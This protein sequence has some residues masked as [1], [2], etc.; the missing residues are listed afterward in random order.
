M[1][2]L[3]INHFKRA[4]ATDIENSLVS[5]IIVDGTATARFLKRMETVRLGKECNR[6]IN[7]TGKASGPITEYKHQGQSH[8]LDQQS[9]AVFKQGLKDN[10]NV[11]TL[12]TYEAITEGK[13]TYK[14]Q[15]KTAEK[16]KFEANKQKPYSTK[17]ND[18]KQTPITKDVKKRQL[19]EV[20]GNYV[21]EILPLGY[22]LKRR[23]PRLLHIMPISMIYKE[24][25]YQLKTKD[26]SLN[27]IQAF[28]TEQCFE[29]ETK[30]LISFEKFIEETRMLVGGIN[31]DIF[32][33]I[34]FM[35]KNVQNLEGKSYLSMAQLNLS[36]EAKHYFQQF[37][38]NNQSRYKFDATDT[39]LASKATLCEHFYT[40][41]SLHL[42]VFITW[43][44]A[45]GF[46]IDAIIRTEKNHVFF[47]FVSKKQSK[48][49]LLP[50]LLPQRVKRLAN[51]AR[52]SK[53][54]LLFL[55]WKENQLHS[56][57][58]FE[59]SRMDE[60]A[61]VAH[62]THL[63]SGK[64]FKISNTLSKKPH[65]EKMLKMLDSINK[66]DPSAAEKIQTRIKETI[67]QFIITD[68]SRI[69]FQSNMFTEQLKFE[70]GTASETLVFAGNKQVRL[71]DEKIIKE[72][73]LG[74]IH[75]PEITKLKIIP[76][77]SSERYKYKMEIIVS[78]ADTTL[79][80]Q[81]IDFSRTGLG[82]L[83]KGHDTHFDRNDLVNINFPTLMARNVNVSLENVPFIVKLVKHTK[84]GVFLGILRCNEECSND[85][86]NFFND[87][88]ERNKKKLN[89]CLKDK[90]ERIDMAF[91]EAY[92]TENIQTI[93]IIINDDQTEGHYVSE[94]GLTEVSC[95][96]AETF[97]RRDY[98]YD[99]SFLTSDARL[100]E[101]N[102]RAKNTIRE[103]PKSFMLYLYKE[104]EQSTDEQ[105]IVSVADFEI[106]DQRKLKLV[107]EKTLQEGG[108]CINVQIVNNLIIDETLLHSVADN[109]IELNKAAGLRFTSE[110]KEIIG[111]ADMVDLTSEYRFRER[112]LQ[113][114]KA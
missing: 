38:D 40:H 96:L 29:P 35:I 68:I 53:G 25:T 11:Y 91:Y 76:H 85:V 61:E 69:F 99:L 8:Y 64:I 7:M 67:A 13:H 78:K 71:V 46:N 70:A 42:P 47:K 20:K 56:A 66:L 79:K 49:D 2:K 83:C 112:L 60:L 14:T 89:L 72:L 12:G 16:Q 74:S 62:Q 113:P 86:N 10:N 27:G 98:G 88:I 6:F 103:I 94:V 52:N 101:F 65:H 108:S 77:R 23:E 26:F 100:K 95:D 33:N 82:L 21:P 107:I 5:E 19:L 36:N 111:F 15:R 50:L 44:K 92:V 114:Q 45:Q 9:L 97:Y 106:R 59:C 1:S 3:E 110:I 57:F 24:Q 104:T 32:Q 87:L 37:M 75:F 80:G 109:V 31:S 48:P 63:Q 41:N 28:I 84:E 4:S 93:P 58:D 54:A 30:V 105:Y 81:T 18:I 39:L 34:E 51:L 17:S 55:Y 22:L 102:K 43:N 73:D 90:I